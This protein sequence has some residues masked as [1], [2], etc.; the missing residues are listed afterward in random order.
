MPPILL[1]CFFFKKPFDFTKLRLGCENQSMLSLPITPSPEKEH[2]AAYANNIAPG[3]Q[4]PPACGSRAVPTGDSVGGKQSIWASDC[5]ALVGKGPFLVLL[6]I[7]GKDQTLSST[8]VIS[9]RV[10][11]G[12]R[13]SSTTHSETVLS[14]KTPVILLC[15]G[16]LQYFISVI[17]TIS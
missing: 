14:A 5:F 11:Q 9:L 7:Y 13:V 1:R 17:W 2:F 10:Q 8:W 12:R 4:E 16:I 3:R 15:S 6:W